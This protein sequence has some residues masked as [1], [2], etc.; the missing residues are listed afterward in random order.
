MDK[1]RRR[2]TLV[3]RK[4]WTCTPKKKLRVGRCGTLWLRHPPKRPDPAIYS[5]SEILAQ[6]AEPNWN[7]PDIWTNRWS[8]WRLY[9]ELKVVVRNLSQETSA[10]NT[11]VHLDLGPFGIGVERS[12]IGTQVLNL[13]PGEER[14]LLYPMPQAVLDGSPYVS[15]RVRIANPADLN[16]A[17]N[18]GEQAIYGVFTSQAGRNPSMEFPVRNPVNA[19]QEI[20]LSV[21]PN[22]VGASLSMPAGAFEPF[23]QRNAILSVT[24]PDSLHGD[25]SIRREITVL[26]TDASDRVIGGVTF[27]VRIDD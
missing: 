10:V 16:T 15:A 23:E 17:N 6:G 19:S 21:M 14:E 3:W 18:D 20:S 27:L 9:D 26:G 25:G 4:G 2:A 13:E 7:S 1:E 12:T 11:N 24:I 8:P 5:Q 22:D